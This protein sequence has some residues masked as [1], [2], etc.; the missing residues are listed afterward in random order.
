MEADNTGCSA[1]Y[2]GKQSS[3][4]RLIHMIETCQ[5]ETKIRIIKWN[6]PPNNIHKLNTDGSALNNPR[7]IGGER[8]LRD[9]NGN[10]A[11]AFTIPLGIHT[12]YQAKTQATTHGIYWFVQHGYERIIFVVDLK[13]L[14]KWINNNIKPP[15]KIQQHLKD[16][17][18]LTVNW[19]I[20]NAFTP[21][22]KLT[23]HRISSAKEV[24]SQI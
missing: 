18:N 12:N 11:Y 17:L 6:R 21:L 23:A 7:K 16:L 20:L 2:G 22:E 24:T 1:K 4:A 5:H 10:M 9:S 3:I 14:T 19:S 15:W 13:L 8:I